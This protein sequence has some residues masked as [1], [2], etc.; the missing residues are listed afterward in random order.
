MSE[1]HKTG[2][3]IDGTAAGTEVVGRLY[4]VAGTVGILN[5]THD[6]QPPEA[7]DPVV[8]RINGVV[9]VPNSGIT[10]ADGTQ[11]GYDQANDQAVAAGAGDFNCGFAV[12]A[13]AATDPYIK[14]LLP[15]AAP[16]T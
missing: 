16:V 15:G 12:G 6:S 8:Y 1:F 3:E 13:H 10:P 11:I 7:G 2:N 4:Q 5:P 9:K 14:V